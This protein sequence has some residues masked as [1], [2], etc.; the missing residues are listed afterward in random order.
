MKSGLSERKARER[1][2]RPKQLKERHTSVLTCMLI[3]VYMRDE[4]SMLMKVNAV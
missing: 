2:K 3:I 1:G 4:L